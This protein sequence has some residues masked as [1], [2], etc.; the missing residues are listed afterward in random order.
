MDLE[1]PTEC[2]GSW[3][4]LSLVGSF[5]FGLFA[6]FQICAAC[7]NVTNLDILLSSIFSLFAFS[8][9][10]VRL[11]KGLFFLPSFVYFFLVLGQCDHS[12]H[13]VLLGLEQFGQFVCF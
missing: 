8:T 13:W 12:N 11:V 3:S 1:F 5:F 2:R 9:Y 4:L 6:C 7:L 10:I